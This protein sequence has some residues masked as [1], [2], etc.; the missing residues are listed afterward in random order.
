MLLPS[1]N[2][3]L[4]NNMQTYWAIRGK[5]GTNQTYRSS[6]SEHSLT[7]GKISGEVVT[8][9]YKVRGP[10]TLT[11][12]SYHKQGTL[13]RYSLARLKMRLS[14]DLQISLYDS[15]SNRVREREWGSGRE[16]E[17]LTVRDMFREPYVSTFLREERGWVNIPGL[18]RTCLVV[19]YASPNGPPGTLG[20]FVGTPI[21]IRVLLWLRNKR[22]KWEE[23]SVH[24][25]PKMGS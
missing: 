25:S 13:V 12:E 10:R 4:V 18:V 1:F 15:W 16:R 9:G 6:S 3:P 24:M 5:R 2:P 23:E 11:K 8:S 20:N 21:L 19:V 14:L 22:K 7:L 17:R